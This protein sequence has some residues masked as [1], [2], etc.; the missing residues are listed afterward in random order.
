MSIFIVN[1]NTTVNTCP[2]Q[3]YLLHV[4]VIC[5]HHQ[6]DFT[7]TYMEK[8]IKVEASPSYSK[9]C[10]YTFNKYRH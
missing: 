10:V 1:G 9:S 8:N 5:S 7:T 3:C 4:V 6:I 2:F